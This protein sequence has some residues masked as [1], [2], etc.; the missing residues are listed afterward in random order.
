MTQESEY[1][2][3]RIGT[4]SPLRSK[5][6][7]DGELEFIE[8]A[9]SVLEREGLIS[10]E[11]VQA[12]EYEHLR[13]RLEAYI[14]KY[15]RRRHGQ[16]WVDGGNQIA[17]IHPDTYIPFL[18]DAYGSQICRLCDGEHTIG[19]L[20]PLLRRDWHILPQSVLVRDLLAFLLLL[21][22]LDLIEFVG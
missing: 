16:H 11:M 5:H 17:V 1:D 10:R 8:K 4:I 14:D 22:E 7:R 6:A 12:I 18:L 9:G 19:D 15:P 3:P 21:E 2:P 20:I 13:V